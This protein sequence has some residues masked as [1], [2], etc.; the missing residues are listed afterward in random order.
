MYVTLTDIQKG[1]P[2]SLPSCI[3]N[4]ERGFGV[5]LCALTYY[6]EWYNI[7]S[8]LKNDTFV[9]GVESHVVPAGY[10]NVCELAKHFEPH[11][12]KLELN[13]PTGRCKI[14]TSGKFLRLSKGLSQSLGFDITTVKPEQVLTA[15]RQPELAVHREVFVHLRELSTSENLLNGK[16]STLLYSVSVENTSCGGGR[17]VSITNRMYK[18]LAS[19]A[20]PQVTVQVLDKCDRILD[21]TYA[22][23]VLHVQ[24]W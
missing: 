6:P 2:V 23:A 7:S 3:E 19:G 8:A 12:V 16:P 4:R 1:E 11:G 24:P 14:S 13:A 21:L 18:R 15:S 22:S 10:Y 5:A 20:V 17:T 9:I